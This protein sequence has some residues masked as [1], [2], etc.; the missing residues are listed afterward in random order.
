MTQNQ[1]ILQY[2]L[3]GGSL[4][5]LDAL[6]LFQTMKLATRISELRSLG[7]SIQSKMVKTDSGKKVAVY[8]MEPEEL[9]RVA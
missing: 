6:E 5:G 1:R 7:H 8:W 4:T 3:L 2:L 9:A